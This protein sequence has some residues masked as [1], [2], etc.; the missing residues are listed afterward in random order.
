MELPL[1]FAFLG[2]VHVFAQQEDAPWYAAVS[3]F[4]FPQV[5]AT[6]IE[7][8]V[9]QLENAGTDYVLIDFYAPWCPHCQH[10][11]P[12]FERLA[13]AIKEFDSKQTGKGKSILTATVDCV[14]F[15]S[16]CDYWGVHS[17]PTIL[18]GKRDDWVKKAKAA[19]ADAPNVFKANRPPEKPTDDSKDSY[20]IVSIDTWDG[21]A[22]SVADWIT[23]RTRFSLDLSK[24]SRKEMTRL[25]Y[26]D[27]TTSVR[28]TKTPNAKARTGSVADVWDAQLATALLLRDIL[29]HHAFEQL[30]SEIQQRS[31]GGRRRH[32]KPAAKSA[33]TTRD[34]F[35]NFVSLLS[36]RFPESPEDGGRCR[37]SFGELFSNLRDNWAGMTQE[38]T[39]IDSMNSR[40]KLA[41][42][43][44]D[45][46]EEQW[47]LCGEDWHRFSE[48]WHE[49]KGTWPGKRG[50]TCGLWN[51]FHQ[52]AARMDDETALEDTRIIRTAI[53]HFFDCQ[54]CR[55]HFLQIPLPD[56]ASWTRKDAQLWWWNAHNVV[57]R[58]VGKI[59]EQT[60]DG[61]PGYPKAQWPTP[62][63]CPTCRRKAEKSRHVLNLRGVPKM[64]V[65]SVNAAGTV[66][67]APQLLQAS[68]GAQNINVPVESVTLAESV[69]RERW[70]LDEVAA[71]LDRS[72]IKEVPLDDASI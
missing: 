46:L 43:D 5:F 16:T 25:M 7:D 63:E 53:A 21:T 2:F 49:C 52:L 35:M 68:D 30:D 34:S 29:E 11:A 17:Y 66:S 65:E 19:E 44:P 22:E 50:F 9:P 28:V 32:V 14:R 51:L 36:K 13:L 23:N 18:W 48:G 58:R 47:Q 69:E 10:F 12:D 4:H 20:G 61:D 26:Q 57:N 27:R 71:F 56:A 67:A 33:N 37:G 42:I 55:D 62:E 59:E 8:F 6:D 70:N 24:I 15:Y 72:Y 54:E 45:W 41:M 40:K 3:S 60:G 1:A 39:T 38:V 31:K 64:A